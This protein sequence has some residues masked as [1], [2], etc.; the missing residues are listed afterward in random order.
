LQVELQMVELLIKA[1]QAVQ[2]DMVTMVELGFTLQELML[3]V[4]VVVVLAL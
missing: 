2:L 3:Q 1:P 4:A